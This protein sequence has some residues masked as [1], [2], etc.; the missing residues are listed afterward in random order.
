MNDR[1]S[2][3]RWQIN[4]D[5]KVKLEGAEAYADS[6]VMDIN[7]KGVRLCQ[8]QKLP[9][10]NFL[11][12]VI[13][14]S[15]E[16]R[17]E[18]E[19]WITWHKVV[20]EHNIYGLYFEKIKDR[21]KESI[22]RFVYK[23]CPGEMRRRWWKGLEKGGEAMP[24]QKFEDKRIFE[25]IAAKLPLRFLDVNSNKEGEAKTED[26]SAKGIG[27][28]ADKELPPRTSL[29]MWINVPDKGEPLY[30]RGAVVW[31]KM[32]SPNE[33]RVGVN[34]ERADMMGLSRILRT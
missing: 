1:R 33:Y 2:F 15:E 4:K 19:A 17:I 3:V 7:L 26:I 34:L 31:S 10:D 12:M 9:L 20:D 24:E 28:V 32:L 21:D 11:K 8:K 29:E 14:L 6:K 18:V 22:Y 13:M 5:V 25:R 27:L 30:T 16:W 23:H